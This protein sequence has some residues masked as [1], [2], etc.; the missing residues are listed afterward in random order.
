MAEAITDQTAQTRFYKNV[1]KGHET[2]GMQLETPTRIYDVVG[3]APIL[4]RTS[5]THQLP[6]PAVPPTSGRRSPRYDERELSPKP[7]QNSKTPDSSP[8]Q[9]A[10]SF[11]AAQS[12]SSSKASAST[13]NNIYERVYTV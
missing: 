5:P 2:S 1:R 13:G 3:P 4:T 12:V 11:V 10:E 9:P 8:I 6:P 7:P